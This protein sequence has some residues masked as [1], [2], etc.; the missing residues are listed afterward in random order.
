MY[1]LIIIGA[2][3]AGLAAS[4]YASRYGIGHIIVGQI[5]GGQISE[6]HSIDNYPGMEDMSGFEFAKKWGDHAKKYGAEIKPVLVKK[7]EKSD[8]LFKVELE[9]NETLKSK[10]VLL[11]TGTKR[12]K[13][14]IPGEKEFSGK[15]VSY[16]AT[17]DGFFYKNKTVGVIGG[18]N[19]AAGAAL[20]LANICQKVYIIYRKSE[21]RAEPFWVD[22]IKKNE[23]IEVIYNT[24]VAEI[25]GEEKIRKVKLDKEHDGKDELE[26]NGLFIEAG[27]DPD[28]SYAD[29][30]KV[31]TDEGGYVK[32]KS[33]CATSVPGV[34]SAGDITNGSDKFRQV[35]TA[36]A[37]GAIAV[38]S[39]FNYL[40][41]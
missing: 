5:L 23:K 8:D 27:S 9:N 33:D 17:C 6:T 39:V 37:E 38:R 41:K 35:I 11:A 2:G 1:D 30:L 19:S 31:E 36:A 10:T 21:L 4:I 13:L 28:I 20:Y 16:C 14:S 15:G 7:I 34:W 40:K 22:L 12:R 3:P 24:N 29:D 25:L 32:I 18:S 26:V